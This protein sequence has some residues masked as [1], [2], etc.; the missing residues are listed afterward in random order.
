M[1]IN[2]PLS[3]SYKGAER[4]LEQSQMRKRTGG[5][6]LRAV[7]FELEGCGV[8]SP[9]PLAFSF[10]PIGLGV[11]PPRN[12]LCQSDIRTTKSNCWKL[13]MPGILYFECVRDDQV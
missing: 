4:N 9:A 12:P 7:L 10:F 8:V 3:V 6:T 2:E 1:N 11:G 5:V 13:M